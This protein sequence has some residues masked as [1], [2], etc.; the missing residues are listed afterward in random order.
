ME[1]S[2]LVRHEVRSRFA[3]DAAPLAGQ[4]LAATELPGLSVPGNETLRDRVHLA[5]LKVAAGD[6]TRLG[7]ALRLAARDW[8]DLLVTA[9]LADADWPTVLRDAGYP[10][11]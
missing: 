6:V 3:P 1:V 4:R 7:D 8:R 9:D 10:V 2:A 5:V 11:P